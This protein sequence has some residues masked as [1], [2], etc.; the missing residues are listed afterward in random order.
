VDLSAGGTSGVQ[1]VLKIGATVHVTPSTTRPKPVLEAAAP[2]ENGVRV[3]LRNDGD[4]F[5]YIDTLSLSFGS[6][7]VQG[8]ELG[9]IA[10]RTL[11]PPGA[12]REFVIPG[13]SGQPTLKV[14]GPIL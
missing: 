12:K 10:G 4:R 5:F 8:N 9:D 14:I 6:K 11:I 2:A 13:V 7:V 3:M 1:R